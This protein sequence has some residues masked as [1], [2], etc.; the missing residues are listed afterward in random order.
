MIMMCVIYAESLV[1]DFPR[2]TIFFDL[3]LVIGINA[4]QLG[5][6]ANELRG[7]SM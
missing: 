3:C 2:S 7:N 1:M 5:Q 6:S 4:N